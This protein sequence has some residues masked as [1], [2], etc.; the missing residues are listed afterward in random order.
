MYIDA[1]GVCGVYSN[2]EEAAQFEIHPEDTWFLNGFLRRECLLELRR[3]I[4]HGL[5]EALMR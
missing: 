3:T 4:S 1:T 5:F 2:G